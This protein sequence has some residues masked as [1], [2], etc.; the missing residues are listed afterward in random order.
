VSKNMPNPIVPRC[1]SC[2]DRARRGEIQEQ[3][4]REAAVTLQGDASGDVVHLCKQCFEAN[5]KGGMEEGDAV[6]FTRD[7]SL[8]IDEDHPGHADLHKRTQH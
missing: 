7:A 6:T 2:C 3:E 1:M 5:C 8:S 4:I